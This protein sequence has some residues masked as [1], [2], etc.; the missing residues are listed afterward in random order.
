MRIKSL[1][2]DKP[3]YKSLGSYNAWNTYLI[4]VCSF[5][6]NR[7]KYGIFGGEMGV[8]TVSGVKQDDWK[9][10]KNKEVSQ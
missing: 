2:L 3:T 1:A 10:I 6:R 7:V 5:L 9:H 8:Q 4:F